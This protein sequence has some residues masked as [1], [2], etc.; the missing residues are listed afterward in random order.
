[1]IKVELGQVVQELLKTIFPKPNVKWSN[2]ETL[3]LGR[4]FMFDSLIRTY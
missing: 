4:V 3:I 1:M 2:M